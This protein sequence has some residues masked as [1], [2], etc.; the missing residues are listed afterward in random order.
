MCADMIDIFCDLIFEFVDRSKWSII[1]DDVHN[2]DVN[3]LPVDISIKIDDMDFEVSFF[4]LIRTGSE[5]YLSVDCH[6]TGKGLIWDDT[7]WKNNI[8]CRKTYTMTSSITMYHF[9][10]NRSKI[11]KWESSSSEQLFSLT[12]FELTISTIGHLSEHDM[13]DTDAFELFDLMA[14]G[15]DHTTNLSVFSFFEDDTKSIGTDSFYFTRLSLNKFLGN[16]R[17]F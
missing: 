17:G 11:H 8:C 14:T 10:R 9:S 2:I 1:T 13:L 5:K 4:W 16:R 6:A 15:L 7:W 12:S 3:I